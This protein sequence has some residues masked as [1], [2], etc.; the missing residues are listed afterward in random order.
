MNKDKLLYTV[1]ITA[2]STFIFVLLLSF[3][4]NATKAKVEENNRLVEAKAYLTAAGIT[5]TEEMDYEAKFNTV[6]P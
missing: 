3:A 1:I 5:L 4:N 6:Y 2:V